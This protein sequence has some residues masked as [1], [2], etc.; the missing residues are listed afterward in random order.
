MNRLKEITAKAKKLYASGKFKKWTD[1]IKQASKSIGSVKK[2]APKKKAATKKKAAPKKK[3]ARN[4]GSHKD[5]KS[6][7]VNI[8]VVSG[9]NNKDE[10]IKRIQQN[11]KGI[12]INLLLIEK[13]KGIINKKETTAFTKRLYKKQIEN[14]KNWI[15]I[16]KQDN[17]RTK[18]FI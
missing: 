13:Y 5:T 4:Y 15:S 2:A 8:K 17:T 9:V 1:A 6:H 10:A 18:K 12:E 11:N 3:V 7:N 16:L 14:I